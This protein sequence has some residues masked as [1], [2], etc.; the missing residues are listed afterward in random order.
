MGNISKS[1]LLRGEHSGSAGGETFKQALIRKQGH[2]VVYKGK[3]TIT[4]KWSLHISFS[5]R[6]E[7]HF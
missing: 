2:G 6:K 5:L 7:H 1:P 3:I 4:A